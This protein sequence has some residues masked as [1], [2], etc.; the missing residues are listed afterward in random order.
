MNPWIQPPKATPLFFITLLIVCFGPSQKS[1]AVSPPPDG[2]YPGQ[3]TAEGQ[4]ALLDL[5]TGTYNTAVGWSSLGFLTTGSFNTAVGAG[6]LLANI[7]GQSGAGSQNTATG[8]GALLSNTTG[9]QNTAIGAFA[10]LSNT[11][12]A[13]N[14]AVGSEAL[15]NNTIGVE[16]TAIG[17]HALQSNTTGVDNT[18]IGNAAL[19]YNTT[20]F[21]N[22]ALG[23]SACTQVSTASNVICIGANGNNV[24]NSCYI[25]NIFGATS[26]NGVGV[27]VNSN[28]RLGT[29]TSS[30]R[31]KERIEPMGML[32]RHFFPSSQLASATKS[33]ST[34]K[35]PKVNR[36]SDSWLKTWKKLIPI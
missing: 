22:I 29:T 13:L 20:G 6:A 9:F 19:F 36:S 12:G 14:T 32:A 35:A 16:N 24:D 33:K 28:G 31:F 8:V 26:S 3:N 21:G 4:S 15:Q 34:R 1:E 17:Y 27:F 25:G 5:T 10:L 7:G 23:F 30:R 18:A 2:G 11:D